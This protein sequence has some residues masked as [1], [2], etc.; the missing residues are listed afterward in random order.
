LKQKGTAWKGARAIAKNCEIWKALYKP[1][2]S[3][4]VNNKGATNSSYFHMYLVT[5]KSHLSIIS[6]AT[7]PRKQVFLVILMSF[8]LIS[9]LSVAES[10]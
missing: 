6:I 3:T 9:I 5:N 10:S 8:N 1:P 7:H 2:L 4:R